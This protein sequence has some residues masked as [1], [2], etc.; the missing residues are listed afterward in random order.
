MNTDHGIHIAVGCLIGAAVSA[1][2]L[3]FGAGM[4]W[5]MAAFAVA[6]LLCHSVGFYYLWAKR[7]G[8]DDKQ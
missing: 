7:R 6:M 2:L 8:A 3:I 5:A 1:T 4:Q